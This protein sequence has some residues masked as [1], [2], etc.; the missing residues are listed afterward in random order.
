MFEDFLS[1]AGDSLSILSKILHRFL[2]VKITQQ[3]KFF[4]IKFDEF[5]LIR[6]TQEFLHEVA[7]LKMRNHRLQ[8][9]L[10]SIGL[11]QSIFEL[12]H[13]YFVFI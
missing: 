6:H 9:R 13:F 3:L 7:D 4:V 5:D 2:S 1:Q 10:E 11:E 8:M 12:F